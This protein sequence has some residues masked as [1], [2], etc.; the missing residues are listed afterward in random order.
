M[1]EGGKKAMNGVKESHNIDRM[2]NRGLQMKNDTRH[3]TRGDIF[4]SIQE[5]LN[6]TYIISKQYQI[7]APLGERT[8]WGIAT[9]LQRM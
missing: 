2:D 7:L 5:Q 3:S 6:E 8:V 1:R 9:T 4:A